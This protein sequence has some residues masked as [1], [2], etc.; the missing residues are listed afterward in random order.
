MK[1]GKDGVSIDISFGGGAAAMEGQGMAQTSVQAVTPSQITPE[2]SGAAT[3]PAGP[4]RKYTS[5]QVAQHKSDG[6]CWVV[7]ENKIYDVT[8][9]LDD[10]PGG[11]GAIMLYAG[12]DA[13]KEFLMLHKPEIIEKYGAK[14]LV[15]EL[16]GGSEAK[17]SPAPPVPTTD[18]GKKAPNGSSSS[19]SSAGGSGKLSMAEVQKH[20][21]ADDCYVVIKDNVYDV[22]N[23]LNDHPGGK[24]A[25]LMY[26]G[27]NAT[28]EFEMLHKPSVLTKYGKKLL[29]GPLQ[30]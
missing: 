17:A 2:K 13:T 4:L 9:F 16:A 11:K 20:N 25:L 3:K 6:D 8:D 7:L 14:Y 18:V 30:K 10:H 26:A 1:P 21:S 12:K 28:E 24:G 29:K 15:G 23:F 19:A 5:A 27:K 22:T